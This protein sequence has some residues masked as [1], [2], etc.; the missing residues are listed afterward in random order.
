MTKKYVDTSKLSVREI[1]RKIA[2]K[3]IVKNHYSHQWTKCT[4]ALGLFTTTGREHSFFDEP[5]EKLIGAICYG[6]PIGRN[7][8][9]S[10]SLAVPRTA[11][12]ELVRLFVF[13]GY[14]GNIESYL[15]GESFRW[16]KKNRPDIKALI[17]YSDPMQG[18]VGTVYQATNWIYQGNNIRWSDSWLFRFEEGGKWQHGRT[19]FP[20]YGTND[21]KKMKGLVKNDF[22]VKKEVKKH[23]YVYL[24]GTKGDRKKALRKIKH[25]ILPYPKTGDIMESEIVKIKVHK[26]GRIDG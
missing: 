15:I 24:L 26:F 5:E 23:R 16:L 18:H 21:I 10:I 7:S 19:I 9:A 25:P 14:G 8:G 20:Y 6:D 11:V 17:S 3:L 22:W 2:K 13:D 1:D 4:H 12:F